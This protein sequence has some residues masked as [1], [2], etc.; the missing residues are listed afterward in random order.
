MRNM[1]EIQEVVVTY[2]NNL[3]KSTGEHD[4]LT[5]REIVNQ[6]TVEEN[7]ALVSPVTIEE[8]KEAVFAMHPDKSPGL[9]GLNPAFFQTF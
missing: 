5:D 6:V 3:F 4:R 8:V 7:E 1:E 9:D 2:F